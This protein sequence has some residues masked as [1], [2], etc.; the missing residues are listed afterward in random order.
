M[1]HPSIDNPAHATTDYFVIQVEY[2][3]LKWIVY[4]KLFDFLQ[5]HF[6]LSLRSRVVRSLPALPD[7]MKNQLSLFLQEA[8]IKAKDAVVKVENAMEN[9][10][11]KATAK[12][13]NIVTSLGGGG[14]GPGT[15]SSSHEPIHQ[16]QQ[17]QQQQH[18]QELQQ[19]HHHQNHVQFLIPPQDTT[20]TYTGASSH[21]ES[22]SNSVSSAHSAA[23]LL[24]RNRFGGGAAVT[25]TEDE[26]SLSPSRPSLGPRTHTAVKLNRLQSDRRNALEMY[27]RKLL[28]V[29]TMKVSVEL[30]QFL[31]ISRV[32]LLRDI[33]SKG[34]EGILDLRVGGYKAWCLPLV[35][36]KF[37]PVWCVVKDSYVALCSS[38]SEP[39]FYIALADSTFSYAFNPNSSSSSSS[40]SS[41][42]KSKSTLFAKKVFKKLKRPKST[43][44]IGG[45]YQKVMLQGEFNLQMQLFLESLEKLVSSEWCV[46]N[47]RFNSFSPERRN[48]QG[49][50]GF[51]DAVD[52]CWAVSEA[53]ASAKETIYIAG[54][55]LSPEFYLRRPCSQYPEFRLDR[56]LKR[57]ASEGVKIYVLIYKEIT[58]A[59]PLQSAYTKQTLQKLD[60]KHIKVL[61]DPDHNN[62]GTLLWAH[63]EKLV[64]VDS[65]IAFTGGVDLAYGRY[66]EDRHV[67]CDGDNTDE[68]WPG[69]HYSNPRVRDFQNVHLHESN[70]ISKEQVARM[71]WHDI[72]VMVCGEPA[73]DLARHFIE[74]W[75]WVKTQKGMHRMD[76]PMLL[77]LAPVPSHRVVNAPEYASLM[78]YIKS[79][80][81][82]YDYHNGCVNASNSVNVQV[83][84]SAEM[85]SAGASHEKSI[86]NAYLKL[87]E[88]AEHYVYIENQFFITSAS[89]E[90]AKVH[91]RIG[92]A[93]AKRILRA[94]SA[95]QKFRVIIV[96]PLLPAFEGSEF[97]ATNA[98][99]MRVVMHY[100]Y[101]SLSRGGNSL[102]ERLTK[103]GLDWKQYIGVFGLRNWGQLQGSGR[104]VSEMVYVHSKLMIVDDRRGKTSCI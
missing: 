26:E 30:C 2:G 23:P 69:L 24:N 90:N 68:L 52:Y 83:V 4:R 7:F 74:R 14:G 60:F 3:P 36:G 87:I 34:R 59:L 80:N 17:H 92:E 18:Q 101:M 44:V 45:K 51:V 85:W 89:D 104:K 40:S 22:A 46:R 102:I 56:L 42:T 103:E 57:K 79:T 71:P 72:G 9:M 35:F 63:H 54:W 91:N 10:K 66:D 62:G 99:T 88:E 82:H 48:V 41:S 73:S 16:Q 12:T 81:R 97:A 8:K 43:L 84:R 78:A 47:K 6:Q 86:Y 53:I 98:Q 21:Q 11:Q 61:R 15:T 49:V 38:L 75:N 76:V 37:K 1:T 67:L 93:L 96:M 25:D 19:N 70:L 29:V 33:G 20:H 28:Q 100:Q 94:A 5:L 95:G 50:C 64:V 58:F 31:E 27:L 39:P 55:W 32:S 65:R 13:S 77:P